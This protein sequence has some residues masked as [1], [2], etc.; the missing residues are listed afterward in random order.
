[1]ILASSDVLNFYRHRQWR[2]YG[3][4]SKYPLRLFLLTLYFSWK[5]WGLWVFLNAIHGSS[6]MFKCF[7]VFT[8]TFKL[9]VA[10]FV[11]YINTKKYLNTFEASQFEFYI[12]IYIWI[13]YLHFELQDCVFNSEVSFSSQSQCE[14]LSEWDNAFSLIYFKL[15][16]PDVLCIIHFKL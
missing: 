6:T 2:C 11:L 12:S 3:R 7:T 9:V 14:V 1:M 10:Y 16:C 5:Y 15:W 4:I 8:F 13:T